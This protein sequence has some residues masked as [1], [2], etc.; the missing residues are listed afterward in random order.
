MTASPPSLRREKLRERRDCFWLDFDDARTSLFT[1][2]DKVLNFVGEEIQIEFEDIE[3]TRVYLAREKI[4]TYVSKR[5]THRLVRN[6]HFVSPQKDS[7]N[8]IIANTYRKINTYVS[9]I[10]RKTFVTFYYY[11]YYFIYRDNII[12]R[13]ILYSLALVHGDNT[14]RIVYPIR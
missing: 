6:S 14:S 13:F 2:K 8:G 4:A 10:G 11:Y 5:Y 1:E 9:I 12:A 7:R 3:Y